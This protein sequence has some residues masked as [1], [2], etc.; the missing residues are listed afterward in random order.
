MLAVPP[1]IGSGLFAHFD[2]SQPY[3]LYTNTGRT[4]SVNTTGDAIGGVI[5][6][7]GSAHHLSRI[8]DDTTRPIF[9]AYGQNGLGYARFDGVNDN[10]TATWTTVA[11]PF[12][13]FVVARPRT[14]AVNKVLFDYNGSGGRHLLYHNTGPVPT[15][16]AGTNLST[17]VESTLW[18]IYTAVVNGLSSV[19]RIDNASDVTGNTGSNQTASIVLANS[20]TNAFPSDVDYGE[21]LMYNAAL[22]SGDRDTI[23][24]WLNAKWAIY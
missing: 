20:G 23:R 7:S 13:Y 19:L 14:V 10:L 6:L 16:F 1:T 4:T 11:Q 8:T 15:I 2:F 12:T 21:L 18:H 9:Y 3:G 17:T 22:S 24:G 5:D